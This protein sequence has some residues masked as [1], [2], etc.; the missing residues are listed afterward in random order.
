MDSMTETEFPI[1]RFF[2]QMIEHEGV[3]APKAPADAAATGVDTD[4]LCDLALKAAHTVRECTT[5][6]VAKQMRLPIALVEELMQTLEAN[7]LMEVHGFE[8]PFNH[9]YA[10]S[11]RGQER[12]TRLLGV[13]GYIG[14]APVALETYTT[15]IDLHQS[16]FPLVTWEDVQ[17]A[18]APLVLHP[19]DVLTA[20]LAVMSQRSLFLF[21]PPGNGKTSVARLLHDVIEGELWIPH[22]IV[23]GTTIIQIFDPHFHPLS[24]FTTSQPWKLD[25]RWVRIRRPLIVA[26]G[27]MSIDSLELSPSSLAGYFEAPMHMKSNGGTFVIDDF[28]RQRVDPTALL[29]RWIVPMEHGYDYLSLPTG[30]KFRVPFQQMLVVATNLDPDKVVDPA[31]LRR[32]G[33]RVHVASPTPTQYKDIFLKFASRCEIEVPE[34][35]TERLIQ[36]YNDEGRELRG[37]EP[38][39]LIA[40]IRDI[41]Q[42]RRQALILTD[43]VIDQAWGSYFGLRKSGETWATAATGASDN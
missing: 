11:A 7:R 18:L 14:P 31:F 27:E 13:S 24:N 25:Q 1:A 23:V 15:M 8:G 29:N 20:A 4:F 5:E 17:A 33:Y 35:F 43:E 28:G 9:R 21:G 26:G 16:Q 22:C 32:M 37:S 6:W 2:P 30:G 40:R 12:V 38:R 41:C 39:D 36:R 42:L 10:V 19:Q 34:G 3:L